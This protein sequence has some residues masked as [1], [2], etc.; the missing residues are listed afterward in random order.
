MSDYQQGDI[1]YFFHSLTAGM[2][3]LTG[4]HVVFDTNVKE[5]TENPPTE[6]MQSANG[7][8]DTYHRADS[9]GSL[10]VT[11]RYNTAFTKFLSRVK[12]AKESFRIVATHR[13]AG[14]VVVLTQCALRSPS[15]SQGFFS[16]VTDGSNG[17]VTIGFGRRQGDFAI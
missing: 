8:S 7:R 4:D 9:H 10:T 3:F 5:G 2:L 1:K 16:P 6:Y 11:P 17:E 13:K 14:K 15:G 12:E